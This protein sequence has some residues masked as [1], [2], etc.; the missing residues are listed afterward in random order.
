MESFNWKAFL[1]AILGISGL[2]GIGIGLS[3]N[4]L[5]VIAGSVL[6]SVASIGIGFSQK[7]KGTKKQRADT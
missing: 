1:L 2:V 4:S 6:L 5:V 3:E 7:S